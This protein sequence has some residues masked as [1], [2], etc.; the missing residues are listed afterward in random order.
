MAWEDDQPA[1]APQATTD[2][3]Q[4]TERT[5]IL[6]PRTDPPAIGFMMAD[7][8]FLCVNCAPDNA[9]D[10]EDNTPVFNSDDWFGGEV[11]SMCESLVERTP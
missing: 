1:D 9:L 8:K 3:A 11:C 7:N 5:M 4:D 6:N 10:N 2:Q